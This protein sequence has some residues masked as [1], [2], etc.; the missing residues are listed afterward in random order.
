MNEAENAFY[1]YA[2]ETLDPV[3]WSGWR[4][5]VNELAGSPVFR[6]YWGVHHVRMGVPGFVSLVD[7]LV[8]VRANGRSRGY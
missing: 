6:H 2:Q 5:H 4:G 7:S 8:A 1:Q 3:I